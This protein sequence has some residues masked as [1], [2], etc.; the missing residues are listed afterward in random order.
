VEVLAS[1][2]GDPVLV[3]QGPI[4][5]STFHPE[6]E[7]GHPAHELWVRSLGAGAEGGPRTR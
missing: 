3:R 7:E 6:M 1:R 2:D 4:V 5:A